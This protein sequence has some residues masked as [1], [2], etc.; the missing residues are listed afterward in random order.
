MTYIP[1]FPKPLKK[2]SKRSLWNLFKRG[3]RSWL[4][5]L[6]EGSYRGDMSRVR[7]PRLDLFIVKNPDLVKE[8]L[9]TNSPSY[10]K[11][12]II[13]RALKPLLGSSIFTTNGEVWER[14]RRMLD[15][16]FGQAKL[17]DVFPLMQGGSDALLN[18]MKMIPDGGEVDVEIEMT[19]VTADII[20]RTIL[21]ESLESETAVMIF[22]AFSEFQE[23]ASLMIQ[24]GFINAP[25]WLAPRTYIVWKRKGREIREL[26][27]KTIRERYDAH[28]RGEPTNHQ[29]ILQALLEVRDPKDGS[30]FTFE[31]LVDQVA[32]LF[33]A[34]HET[35]ASALSWTLFL[36]SKFPDIQERLH[37]EARQVL[38]SDDPNFKNI[39]QLKLVRNVFRETLR[40][41]PPVGFLTFRKSVGENQLG[42]HQVP[43]GSPV[44]VSPWL[45][46]RHRDL[47]NR[48]DE[49]DPDRFEKNPDNQQCSFIPFGQGPRI[50]IGAAFAMQEAMLILASL[51]R[52]FRFEAG[53]GPDPT[54]TAR[55]TIR[56]LEGI[57]LLIRKRDPAGPAND[58]GASHVSEEAPS[59]SGCPFHG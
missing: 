33:L 22:E 10:P 57:K 5:T 46:H 15:P 1:P 43:D 9:V 16:A 50:C 17:K 19:H 48:P 38:R 7:I 32:M 39:H 14:Q 40:L 54:P 11:H 55:L 44:A 36:I 35:S 25:L 24:L 13:D 21:S 20:L 12:E 34:G 29:D 26:L 28:Q 8:V 42:K 41:Y 37:Q 59:T 6:Y 51:V 3:R 47:W 56:S 52:N 53:P 31:E 45:T 2:S 4:D 23:K 18:R 58:D 30:A 49:F 27:A